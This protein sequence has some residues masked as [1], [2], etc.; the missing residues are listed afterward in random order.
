MVGRVTVCAF[1]KTGTLTSD[2]LIL[3][4]A[5]DEQGR[6]LNH[7]DFT[8]EIVCVLTGCH[9]L[10]LH[11][12]K[13]IGDPIERIYFENEEWDYKNKLASNKGSSLSNQVI[14]IF[15]FINELK[16]MSVISYWKDLNNNVQ[17]NRVLCKGAPE[18]IY[19]LLKEK[20]KNYNEIFQ[21]YTRQGYRVLALAYKPLVNENIDL[22]K[23]ENIENDL[24]FAGFYICESPL[25]KDTL[26]YIKIL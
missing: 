12:K 7:K 26:R 19:T 17:E 25:K 6:L 16:R 2:D 1:D 18:T 9:S 11:E 24:I 14:K 5:V 20:P 22:I 13:I 8:P 21:S 15:P 10:I 4:G 3:K 23:R